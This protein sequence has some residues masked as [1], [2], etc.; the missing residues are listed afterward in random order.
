MTKNKNNKMAN[1]QQANG[2]Q[3]M[4]G[5]FGAEFGLPSESQTNAQEVKK[6]NAKSAQK[7]QAASGG[8]NMSSEFGAEFGLPSESQTNAQEVRKQN[9]KSAKKGQ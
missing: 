3:N 2:A 5:E 7:T 8:Q 4:A 9:A 6:Q 1:Q